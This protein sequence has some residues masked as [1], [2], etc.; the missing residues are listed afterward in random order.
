MSI[1]V[2][3]VQ[4]PTIIFLGKQQRVASSSLNLIA[5]VSR[6]EAVFCCFAPPGVLTP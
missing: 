1:G 3:T 6:K 4:Q 5:K 2:D